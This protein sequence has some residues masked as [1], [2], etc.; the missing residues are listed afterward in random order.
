MPAPTPPTT[1]DP[2][3]LAAFEIHKD[4]MKGPGPEPAR[5][6]RL[7]DVLRAMAKENWD[8]G[9]SEGRKF[10]F[11][12]AQEAAEAASDT[13]DEDQPVHPVFP[14]AD[15]ANDPAINSAAVPASTDPAASSDKIDPANPP[16]NTQP[17]QPPIV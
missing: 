9:F 1:D 4:L 16:A 10:G 14:V 2:F 11:A 15:P 7:A 13:V 8:A 3:Q 6:R 5:I 17:D 12:E